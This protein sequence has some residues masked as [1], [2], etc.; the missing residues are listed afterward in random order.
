MNQ[1]TNLI[2]W[3]NL[4]QEQKA[5]FDFENYK[6]EYQCR[7]IGWRDKTKSDAFAL[8]TVYRLVIEP[9]KWYYLKRQRQE[10]EGQIIKG[11]N[12]GVVDQCFIFRP[13]K[14]DEIPKP[15]KTLEQ[16]IQEKYSGFDVEILGYCKVNGWLGLVEEDGAR[17]PHIYAQC[18]KGFYRY[19]YQHPDGDLDTNTSPTEQWDKGVTLQPVAVLFTKEGE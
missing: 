3:K 12:I 10:L 4:T 18:M 16:K 5:D 14:P 13:A 19:V 11:S 6:Y 17:E 15:K 1:T 8:E 7:S 9:D 2:Q